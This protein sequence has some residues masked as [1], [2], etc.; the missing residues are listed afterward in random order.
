MN[1]DQNNNT[2]QSGLTS[3][4]E[5]LSS[6]TNQDRK[7][8]FG[9]IIYAYT[10]AQALADGVQVDVSTTAQEAG[11]RFPVFLTRGVFDKFV[12]VPEGIECQ[13]EAGRLWDILWMLKNAIRQN[14][15][16]AGRLTF[17]L[18]V[19][20]D[21]RRAKKVTLFAECGARDINDPSPAITVTLPNED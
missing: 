4:P 5:Q 3:R 17:Q 16:D 2:N 6:D 11:F 10:R 1:T 13:D 14:R 7:E 9:P 18:F 20:N 8:P 15:G 19:R 21:N 12:S